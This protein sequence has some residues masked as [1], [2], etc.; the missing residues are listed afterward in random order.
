MHQLRQGVRQA[1]GA[2]IVD[3]QDRVVLAQLP[4]AVDDFLRAPLHL[5][6]A[7]LHRV[8]IERLRCWRRSPMLEAAPPPR[9]ISMPGPPSWINRRAVRH[10]LLVGVRGVEILPTPPA[11]MIG[12]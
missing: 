6:V 10:R 3:R 12:L 4:A 11:I 5:G 8:E 9:P 2:D 1:A 7:A